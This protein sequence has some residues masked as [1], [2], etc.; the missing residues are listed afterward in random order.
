MFDIDLRNYAEII[1]YTVKAANEKDKNW[2][3]RVHSISKRKV[4]IRWGYLDYLEEKHPKN[5]FS[6]TI[7][8]PMDEEL[9]NAITYRLPGGEFLGFYD[10]GDKSWNTHSTVE[11]A[12][13]GAIWHLVNYA[14]SRY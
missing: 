1:R 12:I 4:M 10:F 9:W 3:W 6:V 5:C 2:K 8:H 13:E 11:Q 7:D 14:H